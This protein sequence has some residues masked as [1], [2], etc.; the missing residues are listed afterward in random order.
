L[1]VPIVQLYT[2]VRGNLDYRFGNDSTLFIPNPISL[3][4]TAPIEVPNTLPIVFQDAL[5][6][7][8]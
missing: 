7:N 6:I 4:A 2:S 5:Y 3:V 8:E 1:N